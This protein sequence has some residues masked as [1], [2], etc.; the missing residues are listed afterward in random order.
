[1]KCSEV[2][3]YNAVGRDRIGVLSRARAQWLTTLV[4]RN[5]GIGSTG[6]QVQQLSLGPGQC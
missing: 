4:A 1:M 5:W 2:M 3:S 6:S